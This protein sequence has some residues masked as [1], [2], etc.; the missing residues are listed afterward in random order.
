[1]VR[2][3]NH[4]RNYDTASRWG[5]ELFFDSI[6]VREPPHVITPFISL[7]SLHL[8]CPEPTFLTHLNGS[9]LF[10]E[11]KA[12][13]FFPESLLKSPV[14]GSAHSKGSLEQVEGGEGGGEV[15]LCTLI[16]A[17]QGGRRRDEQKKRVNT[18]CSL[19]FWIW[20]LDG[21]CSTVIFQEVYNW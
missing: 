13:R 7:R 21:F 16:Q 5:E 11:I 10:E 19:F 1:V 12:D 4:E 17:G 18:L 20:V 8:A 15:G 2:L 6:G 14:K 9:S 3:S